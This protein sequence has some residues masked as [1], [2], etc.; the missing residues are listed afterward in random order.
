[1]SE[2]IRNLA[3]ISDAD[4][5]Y[6]AEIGDEVYLEF[7]EP[8]EGGVWGIQATVANISATMQDDDRME[9][10]T[11]YLECHHDL[12]DLLDVRLLTDTKSAYRCLQHD[13]EVRFHG[14]EKEERE[15]Q[16]WHCIELREGGESR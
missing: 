9:L 12:F 6:A 3:G 15:V 7:D 4:M 10:R 16:D 11:Y 8:E 5:L 13:I 2:D 14:E 1:M